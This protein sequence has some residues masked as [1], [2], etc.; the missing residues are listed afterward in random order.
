MALRHWVELGEHID[1]NG[2]PDCSIALSEA[3]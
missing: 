3:A 1:L 2:I